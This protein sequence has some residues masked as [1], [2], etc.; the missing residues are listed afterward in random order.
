MERINKN[1]IQIENPEQE[2]QPADTRVW[3]KNT[4]G[5]SLHIN[6]RI[7]PPNG[8]FQ[9]SP[10]EISEFFMD[11]VKPDR[12]IVA[13]KAVIIVGKKP[14]YVLD[15]VGE[16][17]FNILDEKGKKLNESVVTKEVA[18]QLIADLA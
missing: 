3:W 2:N 6:N 11:V 13:P 7:I 9:A 15:Q 1:Q 18:N 10:N 12:P 8:R 5:G 4:G 17:E 16:D 14:K